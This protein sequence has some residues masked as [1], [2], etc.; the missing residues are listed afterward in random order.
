MHTIRT[1]IQTRD[2]TTGEELPILE[3]RTR[4]QEKQ[5]DRGFN[6]GQ[7]AVIAVISM[8]GALLSLLA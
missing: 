6:V 4:T 3:E 7:A 2:E 5:S 8:V 1:T